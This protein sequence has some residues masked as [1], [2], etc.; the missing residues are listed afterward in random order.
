LATLTSGT[1]DL[2]VIGAGVVGVAAAVAAK[3]RWPGERV[4]VLEKEAGVGRHASGRNSGVLHS[5][6]Y[7]LPGGLKAGMARAGCAALTRYCE[8]RGLPIR[9]CGKL[10]V[11]VR[12]GD[13]AVLDELVRRARENGVE[14]HEVDEAGAARLE[15]AAR[16]RG[17]ALWVPSTA[18]VDPASVM[19]ALAAD[20]RSA[21][22]ELRTGEAFRG[23]R[24]DVVVTSRGR[25]SAGYVLNAAGVH[26]DTVARAFGFGDGYRIV[27]FRGRY[28]RSTRPGGPGRHIYPVPD[29]RVPFLGVHLTVDVDGGLRVGPTATPV[30]GR[31]QY[32][33]LVGPA[34][35]AAGALALVRLLGAPGNAGV[36]RLGLTEI[37]RRR[38]GALLR[39]AGLIAR[40]L[41]PPEA[42]VPGR[43]GIRAQLVDTR[44]WTLED[45]FV[46]QADDRS[47]H[48]LNA[49]SPAFTCALPMAEYLAGIM[50][51]ARG[52]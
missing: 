41:P 43:P 42:W 15:P 51:D 34:E 18:S 30:L 8:E 23:R 44:R 12:D 46:H 11:P 17:R 16:V 4:V 26:A 14:A 48:L 3:R 39:E 28:L 38:P 7:Y 2:L 9:R 25:W 5:G 40:G 33:G 31:E 36:R 50:D 1:A 45:D 6:L 13:E 19:G 24:G 10:I 20:A 47:L 29:L 37:R 21:G 35:A 49:V 22:V 52:R 32:H 27:P